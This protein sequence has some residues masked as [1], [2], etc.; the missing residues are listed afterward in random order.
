[1]LN[2][3]YVVNRMVVSEIKIWNA[4]AWNEPVLLSGIIL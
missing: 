3:N 2:Y 4:F 1:M